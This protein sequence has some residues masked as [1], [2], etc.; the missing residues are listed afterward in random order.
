MVVLGV[1]DGWMVST[2]RTF[3]ESHLAG[4]DTVVDRIHQVP[5]LLVG[6]KGE[7]KVHG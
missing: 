2:C 1:G 3:E 5:L 6:S 4:G 7:G